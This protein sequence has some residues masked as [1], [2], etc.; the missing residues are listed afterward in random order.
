MKIM[1]M[2]IKKSLIGDK[3]NL[4]DKGLTRKGGPI[5]KTNLAANVSSKPSFPKLVNANS[6]LPGFLNFQSTCEWYA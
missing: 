3:T 5:D 2:M 6:A 4:K 1:R